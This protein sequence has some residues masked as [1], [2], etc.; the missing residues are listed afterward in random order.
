MMRTI[1]LLPRK[2]F[3]EKHIAALLVMVGAF[4]ML[5]IFLQL[6][7]KLGLDSDAKTLSSRIQVLDSQISAYQQLLVPDNLS[8]I[9]DQVQEE[10]HELL[11]AHKEWMIPI[12]YTLGYLPDHAVMT[13]MGASQAGNIGIEMEFQRLEDYLAYIQHLQSVPIFRDVIV[14]ELS[15]VPAQ[16][17]A[18][19]TEPQKDDEEKEEDRIPLWPDE[20]IRLR[21]NLLDV[22]DKKANMIGMDRNNDSILSWDSPFLDPNNPFTIDDL[23]SSANRVIPREETASEKEEEKEV[24][25]QGKAAFYYAKIEW[26]VMVQE[27]AGG[28]AGGE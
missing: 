5:L 12:A 7:L 3:L 9:Y 1:N 2:P 20:E 6:F 11:Q 26:K 15:Y 18:S 13:T 17:P 14:K 28:N 19:V 25:N 4:T 10:L 21:Q 27:I 8:Q 24:E 22:L 16:K 23:L